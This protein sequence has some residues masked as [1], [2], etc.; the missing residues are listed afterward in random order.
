[1]KLVKNGDL[2]S[3]INLFSIFF[4]SSFT[5]C[6]SIVNIGKILSNFNSLNH[7]IFRLDPS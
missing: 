7:R 5:H 6:A 2:K 3:K 1:M 4:L